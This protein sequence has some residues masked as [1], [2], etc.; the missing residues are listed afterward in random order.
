MA[1]ILVIGGFF[2][3]LDFSI[4]SISNYINR[5]NEKKGNI[6]EKYAHL[7]W[8]ALSTLQLQRQAHEALGHGTWSRCAES[9]PVTERGE[10]LGIL[11]VDNEFRAVLVPATLAEVNS[12]SGKSEGK[13]ERQDSKAGTNLRSSSLSGAST[14]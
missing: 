9:V 5:Y 12:G 7:E 4:E 10:R 8:N 11:S 13:V 14:T 6:K 3:F 2:I 1:I